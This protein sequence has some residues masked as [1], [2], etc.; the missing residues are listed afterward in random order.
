ME[1]NVFKDAKK[2]LYNSEYS[3]SLED[4]LIQLSRDIYY[5]YKSYID[6][7]LLYN[8]LVDLKKYVDR[9]I[10][11][12]EFTLIRL[13]YQL[14]SNGKSSCLH[15]SDISN[16]DNQKMTRRACKLLHTNQENFTNDMFSML[17]QYVYRLIEIMI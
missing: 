13:T 7:D 12:D 3:S 5:K 15:G 2:K 4:K 1:F 16:L 9:E 17:S 6:S 11:K 14:V 10:Y 8:R